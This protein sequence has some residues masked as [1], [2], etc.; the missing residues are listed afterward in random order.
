[1]RN[2]RWEKPE[3]KKVKNQIFRYPHQTVEHQT[4]SAGKHISGQWYGML[5]LAVGAFLCLYG[6]YTQCTQIMPGVRILPMPEYTWVLLAVLLLVFAVIYG[7][8]YLTLWMK[9]IP[10]FLSGGGLLLYDLRHRIALEDGSIYLVRCY[11]AAVNHY[12]ETQIPFWQGTRSDAPAALIFWMLVWIVVSFFVASL[13]GRMECMAVLPVLMLIAGVAVG[14]VPGIGAVCLLVAG[15]VLLRM[16]RYVS[17][18]RVRVHLGQLAVIA[19]ICGALCALLTPFVER[20][21]SAYDYFYEKQLAF[22]DAL[23]ALP[24]AEL[25]SEDGKVTNHTPSGS[26]QEIL[27]VR[28]SDKATENVY[29]RDFAARRY[30]NGTWYA[31][32]DGFARLAGSQDMQPDEAGTWLAQYDYANVKSLLSTDLHAQLLWRTAVIGP[33]DCDFTISY[34]H[35]GQ[36]A[37]VPAVSDLPESLVWTDD[38]IV[39]RPWTQKRYSGTMVMGGDADHQLREYL[40]SYYLTRQFLPY[41]DGISLSELPVDGA[42]DSDE[43]LWYDAYVADTYTSE[44]MSAE[45]QT[46]FENYLQDYGYADA[47][48]ALG[49]LRAAARQSNQFGTTD[50]INSTRLSYALIV[51]EFMQQ[52]GAYDTNLDSL[53]AGS[54]PVDYFLGTSQR[55][56]CVHYASAATM[57]LQA[58]GIPARYATGYVAFASD[59]KETTEKDTDQHVWEAVVRGERAH[60]WTEVYLENIGWIPFEMTRGFDGE[61]GA[62]SSSSSALSSAAHS[63]NATQSTDNDRSQTEQKEQQTTPDVSQDE[64][65]A[66]TAQ[67]KPFGDRTLFGIALRYWLWSGLIVI[68][69]LIL[70]VGIRKIYECWEAHVERTVQK[71]IDQGAYTQAV[72]YINRKMYRMLARGAWAHWE[73][74]RDDT[75]YK[76]ALAKRSVRR[77][78]AIDPDEYMRIVRVARFSD[79]G[80]TADDVRTVYEIYLRCKRQPRRINFSLESDY[81]SD[82]TF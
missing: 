69:L 27:T 33:K 13:I 48:A 52:F 4:V 56:F 55:G 37:C 74:I 61:N 81:E 44:E 78:A 2:I 3:K 51:Q 63:Q 49:Y 36:A 57:I 8:G 20:M 66:Q 45:A 80:S 30:E 43:D 15:A 16:Y 12:Y 41:V 79:N 7:S 67:E 6:A 35:W 22:E 42:E 24:V 60:A 1:M 26:K 58:L 53:P 25:F 64:P 82:S 34:R 40:M 29:L 65:V 19:C 10:F 18:Q 47:S 39:Q 71:M 11:L 17:G 14:R 77:N 76:K 9:C 62:D 21:V 73:R 72:R 38:A 5:L 46:Q 23:L 54:D 31:D 75:A 68:G 59:F 70:I 28:L 32:T 50:A